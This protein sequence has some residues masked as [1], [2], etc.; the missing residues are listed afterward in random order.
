MEFCI[1]LASDRPGEVLGDGIVKE[2]SVDFLFPE[3]AVVGF[4]LLVLQEDIGIGVVE[5][6]KQERAVVY[7]QA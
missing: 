5:I 1:P 7:V 2:R 3:V 4:P 6:I